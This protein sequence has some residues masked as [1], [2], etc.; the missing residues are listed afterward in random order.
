[1]ISYLAVYFWLRHPALIYGICLLLGVFASLNGSPYELAVPCI[2]VW[3]PF[4][5]EMLNKRII[6]PQFIISLTLFLTAFTYVSVNHWSVPLPQKGIAGTALISVEKIAFRQSPFGSKWI[7]QCRIHHYYPA[8]APDISIANGIKCLI[9][10]PETV[11]RPSTDRA[12]LVE[13]KLFES[14]AGPYRLRISANK[15]WKIA[16]NTW[17]LAEERFN[18]KRQLDRWIQNQYKDPLNG[19]FLAGL[20]TGELDL[21]SIRDEFSRFGLLHILA[22]SGFHF[23]IIASFLSFILSRILPRKTTSVCLLLILTAYCLF[24][25]ISASVFRAWMMCSLVLLA[26]LFEK[27]SSALN[28]LG[29]SLIAILFIDPLLAE[30]A[31]FQFSFLITAAILLGYKPLNGLLK[32][33]FPKRS[34]SE[35]SHMSGWD[36][37]GYYVLTLFRQGLALAAAVNLFALPLTL[38]YFQKFPWLSV[39]YN[40]FFPFLISLSISLLMLGGLFSFVPCIA[41]QLHA[42]NEAYIDVVLKLT[43]QLPDHLDAFFKIESLPASVLVPYICLSLFALIILKSY[44]NEKK[45]SLDGSIDFI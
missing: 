25:G 18:W 32:H 24:L 31:G 43:F 14:E 19:A 3:G 41:K 35:V 23:A 33:L 12:Y 7:Y 27:E 15:P 30:T 29:T 34:L 21:P 16:S 2:L 4:L 11:L 37:H 26:R 10:L 44:E 45:E 36:Q 38:F 42:L 39:P 1:M 20:V 40:L 8:Y 22:I 13:G 6:H 28:T 9:S 5:I 17:G